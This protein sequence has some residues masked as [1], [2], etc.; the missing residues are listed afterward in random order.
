MPEPLIFVYS[1]VELCLAVFISLTN[2]FV[3]FVYLRANQLRTPS[4]AHL[5]AVHIRTPTNMYIFSLAI[6][7]F[8]AGAVG[9]PFTVISVLTR[10]PSTFFPCLAIHLI[11]C[12]LCTIS[13]FHLLAMALDRYLSICW[14]RFDHQHHSITRAT[15]KTRARALIT[16]SWIIGSILGGL[17]LLDGF[18]FASKTMGKFTGECYF[19]DVVDYRYLV[20]VIFITTIIIPSGLIAFCYIAIYSHIRHEENGV[21]EMIGGNERERRIVARRKLVRILIILVMTFAICWYPLYIINTFDLFFQ[22][23]ANRAVTLTAVVLSHVNCAL[24]P[25]IYAYGVPGFKQHL[26]R[27]RFFRYFSPVSNI[28]MQGT[29]PAGGGAG[30]GVPL[31]GINAHA[32]WCN[33]FARHSSCTIGSG[34][35]MNNSRRAGSI[36]TDRRQSTPQTVTAAGATTMN[37]SGRRSVSTVNPVFSNAM[38]RE[39][40][41]VAQFRHHHSVMRRHAAPPQNSIETD[42]TVA[43]EILETVPN[44]MMSF[45][46]SFG[47][48]GSSQADNCTEECCRVQQSEI[49]RKRSGQ[50]IASRI[51]VWSLRIF[52]GKWRMLRRRKSSSTQS[53]KESGTMLD[54]NHMANL[55][56]I[57]HRNREARGRRMKRK[58]VK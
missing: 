17:P 11:L 35:A 34:G 40:R 19:T 33:N 16:A 38:L 51:S 9:I 46:N 4:N 1:S 50:S 49:D 31:P 10:W 25:M 2:F 53:C 7:D 58:S 29:L 27:F 24:N 57:K 6:T 54:E 13:T 43:D 8:L 48:N 36:G 45:D 20:Y 28:S 55:N 26:R 41:H 18:G 21:Q 14:R 56:A 12:A 3:I 5:R 52:T 44:A 22:M 30:G 47:T 42:E 37:Q 32:A 23:R 39:S 15:R